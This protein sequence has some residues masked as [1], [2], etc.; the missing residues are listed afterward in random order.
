M[1]ATAEHAAEARLSIARSV[2]DLA[3]GLYLQASNQAWHAAKHAINAVAASRNRNPVQYVHKRDFLSEL[4]E[5]LGDD[6][7][8]AWFT[9]PWQLHGNADQ[10]FLT[11]EAIATSVEKTRLLVNRLLAIAGYP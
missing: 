11:A 6:D 10:G 8:E 7:L 9:Y 2:Q 1:L 5:E 4:A 3:D